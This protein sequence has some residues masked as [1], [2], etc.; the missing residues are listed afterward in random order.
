MKTVVLKNWITFVLHVYSSPSVKSAQPSFRQFP[1]RKMSSILCNKNVFYT[2]A[3]LCSMDVYQNLKQ[4]LYTTTTFG[5]YQM[6]S[7]CCT[8][9]PSTGKNVHLYQGNVAKKQ[10]KDDYTVSEKCGMYTVYHMIKPCWIAL[11]FKNTHSSRHN[12]FRKESFLH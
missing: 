7:A 3:P 12:T 9:G 11:R 2:S 10:L 4:T 8:A 1:R 6:G 5:Y